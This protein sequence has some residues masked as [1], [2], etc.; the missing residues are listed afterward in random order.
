M[1]TYTAAKRN[2][3]ATAETQVCRKMNEGF[4]AALRNDSLRL[5]IKSNGA[6]TPV[7]PIG[8]A[9]RDSWLESGLLFWVMEPS[10]KKNE[11]FLAALRNDHVGLRQRKKTR[12]AAKSRTAPKA[13]NA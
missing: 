10:G 3:E 11:G 2:G 13:N 5:T 6:I 9:M 4:L 7:F 12:A 1:A 8:C